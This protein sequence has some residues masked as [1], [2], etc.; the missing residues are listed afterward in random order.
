MNEA[1]E[2]P[3]TNTTVAKK[4][5]YKP[6]IILLAIVAVPS[7]YLL[8]IIMSVPSQ[9]I[10]LLKTGFVEV[11]TKVKTGPERFTITK[12]KPKS[13]QILNNIPKTVIEP[14]VLSEDWAFFEHEGV[15]F[16]QI[17]KAISDNVTQGKK[18]R[19]ASTI[20]QQLVK[21]LFLSNERSFSR[22]LKEY[23][24]TKEL[25]KELSKK[26]ILELYLNVLHLGDGV[27]GVQRAAQ[28][29]FKK[30]LNKLTYREGAFLAMLLPSPVKYSESFRKK[31]LSPFATEVVDKVIDKLVI[32][33]KISPEQA[34][35]EK[36]RL[37]GWE[38][39]E[40]ARKNRA[41]AAK[42]VAP[43]KGLKAGKKGMSLDEIRRRG[44]DPLNRAGA[45]A[46]KGKQV[47]KAVRKKFHDGTDYERRMKNDPDAQLDENL[48]YDDDALIEDQSGF[49]AEFNVE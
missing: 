26:K 41:A 14:I 7:L 40:S 22:K 37:F 46:Q 16:S 34:E 5:N 19:G 9:E 32:A 31:E 6:L 35:Q 1:P 29:Y 17:K 23:F 21:N 49:E 42:R 10:Q 43:E 4:K 18:L 47:V 8:S 24:Y 27:Y 11:N 44:T 39:A 36:R 48:T 45:T 15:D 30:P 25:E 12:R 20:S 3:N 28:F 13:W 38:N 2:I 33:K